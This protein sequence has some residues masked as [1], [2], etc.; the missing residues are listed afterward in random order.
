MTTKQF[1]FLWKYWHF[2]RCFQTSTSETMSVYCKLSVYSL[3]SH[4]RR[5]RQVSRPF[6]NVLRILTDVPALVMFLFHWIIS[7]SCW[8]WSSMQQVIDLKLHTTAV[9]PNQ[10]EQGDS[11]RNWLFIQSRFRVP[12]L[13]NLCNITFCTLLHLNHVVLPLNDSNLNA[14]Y[15]FFSGIPPTKTDIFFFQIFIYLYTYL[16]FYCVLCNLSAN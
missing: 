8:W 7:S 5:R 6:R 15:I 11:R 4:S 9:Y 13:R 14:L 16:Y 2:S 3:R 10:H 12:L 1:F